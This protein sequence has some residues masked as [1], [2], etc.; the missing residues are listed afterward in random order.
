MFIEMSAEMLYIYNYRWL[1]NAISDSFCS[2]LHPHF[3]CIGTVPSAGAIPCDYSAKWS[4][5]INLRPAGIMVCCLF[6]CACANSP[7]CHIAPH[8]TH[9]LMSKWTYL[10]RVMPTIGQLLQPL[11]ESNKY[12]NKSNP[13]PYRETTTEQPRNNPI[14][15]CTIPARLGG[16]GI[17]IPLKKADSE[18]RSSL[19]I[20]GPLIDGIQ[21]HD[22]VYGLETLNTQLDHKKNV[23]RLNNHENTSKAME[24]NQLLPDTLAAKSNGSCQREGRFLVADGT[25][26]IRTWLYPT[27]GSIPRYPSTALQ[28]E[29]NKYFIK[30]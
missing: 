5:I 28:M 19:A 18:F 22:H 20:C 13:S 14:H 21:S 12:S 9:G 17:S 6:V 4:L 2:M 10:S 11:D 23:R 26:T 7:R 1:G 27:Q 16:L 15:A 29:S 30:L 24:L 25:T 8:L 3:F